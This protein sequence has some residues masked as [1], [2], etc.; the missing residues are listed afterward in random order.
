MSQVPR[1]MLTAWRALRPP[2]R[3]AFAACFLGWTLDSFDYF[4]LVFS[5]PAISAEFH[6]STPSVVNALFL[7]LAFR[8]LGALLFG[9]MAE[10]YGRRPTLMLNIACYS[11][12]Q[13]LCAFAPSLSVLLV[14]RALF[15]VAMGG[16]WGVGAA[17]A[18]ETLPAEGRGFYSGVLQQGYSFGALL[19]SI[20]FGALFLPLSHLHL[21]GHSMAWR[22]LFALGGLPALLTFYLGSRVEE[23]PVW[24]ARSRVAHAS[25]SWL[26]NLRRH[27]GIFLFLV[28]LMTGFNAF[29][30]GSVDLYPTFL[31][32]DRH[33]GPHAVGL[34][35][36]V[37]NLGAIA[38]GIA[39]GSL[40]ERWGRK[41]TI[42]TA[43]LLA[44]PY[45]P[46][47]VFAH[48]LAVLAVGACLLLFMVQGAWGV[49]PAYLNELSPGPVRAVF[50]GLA[51]QL[52]NLFAS[53]ISIFQSRIAPRFGSLG[54]VL[55]L[56]VVLVALYLAAM[57]SLG[58]EPKRG[59][60]TDL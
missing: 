16:E 28:F 46:L 17:L 59:K 22:G 7:T 57:T 49:V 26:L 27:G 53:R 20:A 43:A 31:I 36:V 9:T 24:R 41:R 35:G 52:G 56:T 8:P 6:A 18:F 14:L 25:G 47:Y 19:A 48:S 12:L 60:L 29:S 55:A 3:H 54:P 32:H 38:G 50:P 23:S 33:A 42:V 4:I 40:S 51:Y 15:G 1:G 2:Q 11:T 45:V 13:L 5:I 30:H 21:L 39:F 10:H 34:I 58:R 37:L 44:I